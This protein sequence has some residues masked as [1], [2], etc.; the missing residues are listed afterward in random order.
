MDYWVL[1]CP[2][3]QQEFVHSEVAERDSIFDSF[4][5]P[6]KPDMDPEGTEMICP[7]CRSSSVFKRH[8]LRYRRENR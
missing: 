6:H 8:E 5:G 3:C 4:G 7:H 1:T 2:S